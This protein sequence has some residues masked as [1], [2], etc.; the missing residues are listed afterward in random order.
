MKLTC[1]IIVLFIMLLLSADLWGET[2]K[3]VTREIDD[4]T[5]SLPENCVYT[6]KL[7]RP[8]QASFCWMT[9]DKSLMF[10]YCYFGY[11]GS[12]TSKE[13]LIG[14]AAE[15]GIELTDNGD[16]ATMILDDTTFLD[17]CV[18][19][20]TGIGVSFFYPDDKVGLFVFVMTQQDDFDTIISIITSLRIR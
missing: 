4:F 5:I 9:P 2:Y 1:R 16:I 14:E 15:I 20:R 13:R 7:S 17:F 19:D 12:F 11:D 10:V 3:L 18:N 8:E 6:E